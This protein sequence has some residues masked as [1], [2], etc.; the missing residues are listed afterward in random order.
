M[1]LE[2]SESLKAGVKAALK[3]QSSPCG[4]WQ[5]LNH[6][7][8]SSSSDMTF[9][10][11]TYMLDREEPEEPDMDSLSGMLRFVNQTLALQEQHIQASTHSKA[12]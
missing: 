5:G 11:L 12:S 2:L 1:S 8:L 7:E 6:M 9:N 4:S 10:P 3:P